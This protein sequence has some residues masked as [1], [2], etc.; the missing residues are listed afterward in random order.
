MRP[1]RGVKEIR[2]AAPNPQLFVST[3]TPREGRKVVNFT[4]LFQL[5]LLSFFNH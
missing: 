4:L 2:T 5:N 3:H 1:V